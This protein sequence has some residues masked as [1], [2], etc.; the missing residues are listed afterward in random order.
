M[1]HPSSLIRD[2][3]PNIWQKERVEGPV[4]VRHENLVAR[5]GSPATDA[6]IMT[7]LDVPNKEL[8]ATQSMVQIIEE[9]PEEDLFKRVDGR[10]Q[11]RTS[12]EA[13]SIAE[14]ESVPPEDRVDRFRDKEDE[15]TPL[16]IL[17]SVGRGFTVTED[18]IST[19]S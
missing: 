18:D 2:K 17:P 10:G 15:E 4:L 7:H 19:P 6:F 13:A 11:Q 5:R 12:L 14:S 1:L 16:P 9:G 8:Y 3:W